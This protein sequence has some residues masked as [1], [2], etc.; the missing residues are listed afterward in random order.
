M[1]NSK[2][3]WVFTRLGNKKHLLTENRFLQLS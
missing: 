1:L 2:R 3:L